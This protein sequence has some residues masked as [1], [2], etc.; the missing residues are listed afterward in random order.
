MYISVL[1][2]KLLCSMLYTSSHYY[3][4]RIVKYILPAANY[5]IIKEY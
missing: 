4:D 5:I 1:E 2:L 3:R